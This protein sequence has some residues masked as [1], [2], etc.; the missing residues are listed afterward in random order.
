[1]LGRR[2]V[3]PRHLQRE[4][5]YLHFGLQNWERAHGCCFKSLF[6]VIYCNSPRKGIQGL[7]TYHPSAWSTVLLP[8]PNLSHLCPADTAADKKGDLPRTCSPCPHFAWPSSLS[9]S[10]KATSSQK[11][12][13]CSCSPPAASATLAPW[14][15]CALAPSW[16]SAPQGQG[17]SHT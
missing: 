16:T 10:S 9:C 13:P 11:P 5:T 6:V 17:L 3:L 1:M 7:S 12:S 15:R 8:S 4:P 2:Q 14:T